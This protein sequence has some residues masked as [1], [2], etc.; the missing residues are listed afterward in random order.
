MKSFVCER[1]AER[2]AKE[3]PAGAADGGVGSGADRLRTAR[4]GGALRPARPFAGV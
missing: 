3:D 4:T 2:D 1:G